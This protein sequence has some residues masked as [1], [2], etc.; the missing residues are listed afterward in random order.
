VPPAERI[1]GIITSLLHA[2]R[3]VGVGELRDWFPADYGDV[4]D[5]AFARKFERDKAAILALG[6][7]FRYVPA[8]DDGEGGYVIDR[9]DVFLPPVELDT[10]ALTALLVAGAGALAQG[11]FPYAADLR[12]ALDKIGVQL[13]AGELDAAKRAARGVMVHWPAREGPGLS[14]PLELL[15]DAVAARRRIRVGYRD[16]DGASSE[17]ELDPYRLRRHRA[18][19]HVYGYCHLRGANRTLA[20]DRI[21]TLALADPN[22]QGPDFE[23][24][25]ALDRLAGT[26]PPPWAFEQHEPREIEL[27]LRSELVWLLARDLGARVEPSDGP[28]TPVT[29]TVTNADAIVDWVLG[30][31][32]NARLVSPPDLRDK[33]IDRLRAAIER[34]DRERA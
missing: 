6:V 11:D 33:V 29:L 13:P 18:R 3:P 19:W 8:A 28:F 24:P 31:G 2:K 14:E 5:E 30:K 25:Q 20:V 16:R 9:D 10:D 22:G 7:P 27:A 15:A 23:P 4:S 21:E 34:H 26:P 32:P 12:R 17:R 1:I